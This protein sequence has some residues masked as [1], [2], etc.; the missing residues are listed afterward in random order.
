LNDLI[1]YDTRGASRFLIDVM[2]E[3]IGPATLNKLRCTGGGPTFEYFGRFPRYREDRLREFALSRRS[4]PV[5]STSEAHRQKRR[6][7]HQTAGVT[8]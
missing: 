1:Y 8:A 5:H 3:R 6:Q 4:G 2:N 7:Q